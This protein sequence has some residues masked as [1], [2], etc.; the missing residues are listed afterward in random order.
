MERRCME[1]RTKIKRRVDDAR[2]C[3]DQRLGDDLKR[4]R[5]ERPS[6]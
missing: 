6:I 2:E 4:A 1:R 3:V 5:G